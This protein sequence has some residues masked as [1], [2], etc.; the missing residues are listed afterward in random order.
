M[1]FGKCIINILN[2]KK[3]VLIWKKVKYNVNSIKEEFIK[4]LK[5]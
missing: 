1:K 5:I 2:N 3:I 4:L